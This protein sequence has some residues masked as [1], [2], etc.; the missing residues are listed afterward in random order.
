MFICDS[1]CNCS[2][3][4]MPLFISSSYFIIHILYF[5]AV[6]HDSLEKDMMLF[7]LK[8]AI[9]HN[10][11]IDNYNIL[12][13]PLPNPSVTLSL[14]F[15]KC[16]KNY[17]IPYLTSPT[18][19]GNSPLAASWPPTILA[20]FTF[21]T[22]HSHVVSGGGPGRGGFLQVGARGMHPCARARQQMLNMNA[23]FMIRADYDR[24]WICWLFPLYLF[25][26]NY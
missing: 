4:D 10:K 15:T 3:N 13:L 7:L 19:Q 1:W 21:L 2:W 25:C 16:L 11:E 24:L 23:S 18:C 8:C 12:I 14:R 17:K 20:E 5:T 22:P 6:L 26:S 9:R